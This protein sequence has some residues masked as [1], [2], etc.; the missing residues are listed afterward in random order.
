MK[1]I[2]ERTK[3]VADKNERSDKNESQRDKV[4]RATDAKNDVADR[5][6]NNDQQFTNIQDQPLEN[7]AQPLIKVV[8]VTT[9]FVG[10]V[11][12]DEKTVIEG[13][14][15]S[16][17]NTSG[18]LTIVDRDPGESYVVEQINTS[19]TYGNFSIDREGNWI[20]VGNSAHNELVAG[21][22]VSDRFKVT[23]IDGRGVGYVTIKIV[24]TDDAAVLSSD[25]RTLVETDAVLSTSGTLTITDIDS[26]A[27]FSASTITGLYGNLSID[28]SGAWRYTA[29]SAHDEFIEGSAYQD[30]FTVTA[31][32]G[33]QTTVTINLT[34]SN[35]AA[36]ITGVASGIVIEAGGIKNAAV[37]TPATS[38][39]LFAQDIDNADNTF[40]AVENSS[41]SYGTYTISADGKW[42]YTL[43][44][45]ALAI[46]ALNIGDTLTDQFTVITVDGTTQVVSIRIDGSNDAAE[47][48]SFTNVSNPLVETYFPLSLSGNLSISDVDNESTF[49]PKVYSI[50]SQDSGASYGTLTIDITG[51]WV[52]TASS[53]HSEFIKDQIYEEQF[54]VLSSDGMSSK[55]SIYIRGSDTPAIIGDTAGLNESDAILV[56]TGD[57]NDTAGAVYA[58]SSEQVIDGSLG[59]LTIQID[60]KWS[61]TTRSA[62]NQFI[63][64][65]THPDIFNDIASDNEVKFSVIVYITGTND[66]AVL[67][68]DTR[69][70]VETDSVLSASGKL[71]I[72]DVDSAESFAASTITGL[73]GNLS[74]VSSGA[75]LYTASSAHNEFIDGSPYQDRFT[76]SAVDGTKTTI[77]IDFT[78]SNDAAIITGVSSGFVIEAGGIGNAI[79]ES[80]A[81]SGQLFAQDADNSDNTFVAV[82]GSASYGSYAITVDGKWNYSLDNTTSKVQALNLGDTLTDQF[83]VTTIDGTTQ[84]V[85]IRIDGRNDD[86]II[87]GVSTGS[88]TEAGGIA[89]A[90]AGSPATSGQLFAQDLD[91]ADNAFVAVEEGSASYG[92]Y[93][94]SADGKW[95]YTLDNTTSQVQELN[96]G[97]T[98]TDT[99]TVSSIDGTKQVVSIRID[100]SNDAA[101]VKVNPY[102]VTFV[103]LTDINNQLIFTDT[104][105]VTVNPRFSVI[106]IDNDELKSAKVSISSGL[107]D[108]DVL[109]FVSENGI[110]ALYDDTKGVLSLSGSASVA[111]YEKALASISYSGSLSGLR[112]IDWVVQDSLGA[113]SALVSS[114]IDVKAAKIGAVTQDVY[115]QAGKALSTGKIDFGS[116]VVKIESIDAF[117]PVATIGRLTVNAD[118]SYS[119]YVNAVDLVRDQITNPTY[120]ANDGTKTEVFTVTYEDSDGTHAVDVYVEINGAGSFE[121]LE[122]TKVGGAGAK[123]SSGAVVDGYIQGAIVF[124]D[125]NA[126]GV[127]DKATEAWTITDE[128]GGF[129]LLGG[130]G[131]LVMIGGVD[132]TTGVSNKA[133]LSAMAG[134]SVVTPLTTLIQKIVASTPTTDGKQA[135]PEAAAATLAKQLGISTDV[136]LSSYDPTAAALRGDTNAAKVFAVGVQIQN[137]IVQ[138]AS[139]LG[140]ATGASTKSATDSLFTAFA[141]SLVSAETP[142]QG[143]A[144]IFSNA[145]ALSSILTDVASEIL[146]A[147]VSESSSEADLAQNTAIMSMLNDVTDSISSLLVASNDM[148]DQVLNNPESGDLIGS[149][150]AEVIRVGGG[151]QSGMAELIGASGADIA[152]IAGGSI[153]TP[154]RLLTA[155]DLIRSVTNAQVRLPSPYAPVAVDNIINSVE[156][157]LSVAIKGLAIP[158]SLVEL[159]ISKAGVTL[160]DKIV[161]TAN[162]KGSWAYILDSADYSKLGQGLI[163]INGTATLSTL[164]DGLTVIK[165]ADLGTKT[166]TI[167]SIAPAAPTSLI[168]A[169]IE[170][171]YLNLLDR[172]TQTITGTAGA[173][174]L[175]KIYLDSDPEAIGSAT[176]DADGNFTIQTAMFT[177]GLHSLSATAT[178][179]VGSI[180]NLEKYLTFTV[181]TSAPAV[182][183]TASANILQDGQPK[184]HLVGSAEAGTTVNVYL[185]SNLSK[186]IGTTM[187]DGSGAWVFDADNVTQSTSYIAQA[188]DAAKNIGVSAKYTY[189]IATDLM[190]DRNVNGDGNLSLVGTVPGAA[191]DYQNATV[192]YGDVLGSLVLK[193]DGTFTYSIANADVQYL[194]AGDSRIETFRI[195][196]TQ[197]DSKE[198]RDLS[199]TTYGSNDGPKVTVALTDDVS[200]GSGVV[201]RDLL[202]GATDVDLSNTLSVR[203]LA[204]SVDGTLTGLGGTEVPAGLSI[205]TDGRTLS[206]DT[207]NAAYEVLNTTDTKTI[208]VNYQVSDGS[209]GFVNQTETIKMVGTNDAPQIPLIAVDLDARGIVNP[210]IGIKT[211]VIDVLPIGGTLYS[212]S[213]MTQVVT[214]GTRLSPVDG[215]RQLYF[216][217]DASFSGTTVITYHAVDN[218]DSISANLGSPVTA[219]LGSGREDQVTPIQIRLSATD[220]DGTIASF[221]IDQMPAGGAL[222]TSNALDIA[223]IV[224]A[225]QVI[226][227]TSDGLTLY[228]KPDLNF[229]GDTSLRY[230]AVDNSGAPS[231]NSIGLITINAVNDA[232][233]AV[234]VTALGTED[235]SPINIVLSAS[236]VDGTIKSYVIASLDANGSLYTN[237][238]MTNEVTLGM[239]VT[240]PSLFFKPISDFNGTA[241]FTYYAVR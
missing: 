104:D 187:A 26:L 20:F 231:S 206:I 240:S 33:T 101:E 188:V 180:S 44:N 168:D 31:V 36:I 86:A 214:A 97:D 154:V 131:N 91:N 147:K 77:T 189:T 127:L 170:Y 185:S 241:K 90:I 8:S 174:H 63:A 118:G 23:S 145:S 200:E 3:D 75:W 195:T 17:L 137:T 87:S 67:S 215:M 92:S 199:F 148:V 175:V 35:D 28:S 72:T 235:I 12:S 105:A 207:N 227:A 194:G 216:K 202:T 51:Q 95:N 76:V 166:F 233:V 100:G 156:K 55:I 203:N 161:V 228:F 56:T 205:G 27:S 222:Y 182:A 151:A 157:A 81:T 201:V 196:P 181:D 50:G 224:S 193:S 179:V 146:D 108:G 124:A 99:F 66:A 25:T 39:Q 144:T 173:G 119:Y 89:N 46:Q 10:E 138:A 102:T 210:E 192:V 208:V 155:D 183:I 134:S 160:I 15:D 115:A 112:K 212:N 49:I 126:D 53:A 142:V 47:L 58:Y 14:A 11:G 139:L 162:D 143:G 64:G 78:G 52:Y 190:E 113:S 184:I 74:I 29:S 172:G 24:G 221:M 129:T 83:S 21:E 209:G 19:G 149:T 85:S 128:N 93:A 133:V 34:G 178:N 43:D 1:I 158:L 116:S 7:L 48:S 9:Q 69:A 171:G 123:V 219:L 232:P 226:P 4:D 114:D 70:L 121:Y 225:N 2:S 6:S 211:Y 111:N 106:D 18:K 88:V 57:F 59:V 135:T 98:L 150:L 84:L 5:L 16:D 68:S 191:Q 62:N 152:G 140:G 186:A 198:Y 204:Y 218:N 217:S 22:V 79:A 213:A 73:Y 61:Y 136:D 223:S 159:S 141:K 164:K 176:A 45:T 163:T 42:N 60:G 229:N 238:G 237:I 130:S 234:D 230:H 37:G 197:G 107:Q 239:S 65:S 122:A 38:G 32:D 82:A 117:S 165:T 236:D 30:R 103:V 167:D 169:A 40:I 13:N 153:D 125:A 96:V 177:D 120:Y 110:T 132:V 41:T 109:S 220:V 94:V 71:T 80:P 54:T